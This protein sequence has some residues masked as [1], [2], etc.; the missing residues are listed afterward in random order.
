MAYVT[1]LIVGKAKEHIMP[2]M[3][4]ELINK[5]L[6]VKDVFEHLK[7]IYSNPN[8]VVNAQYQFQSLQMR[9]IDQFHDF[10]SKFLC[11]I[12][13]AETPENILQD[14]LYRKTTLDLQK[15]AMSNYIRDTPFS[16]FSKQCS[17]YAN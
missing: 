12:A 2:H 7:T 1:S 11:L 8:R 16:T 15:L 4:D 5:Y 14:E 9:V 3:C 13:E 17:Q 6:I 10:L